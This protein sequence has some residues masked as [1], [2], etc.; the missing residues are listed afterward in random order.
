MNSMYKVLTGAEAPPTGGVP[1]G[2]LN[3]MVTAI[4][5]LAVTQAA[6]DGRTILLSLLGSFVTSLPAA[7]ATGAIYIFMVGIVTT[8]GG[9]YVIN[10]AGTDVFSG[11]V[12]IGKA[13]TA[14]AGFLSTAN[15]TMTF[16][17]TTTGGLQIGDWVEVQD[18]QTGVWMVTGLMTGS[19]TVATPFSN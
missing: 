5:T 9:G 13:A 16:N 14:T 17:A 11:S 4:T 3:R 18:I 8:S 12:N 1:C 19:G 6:H 15:K 2:S 7:T 10:T